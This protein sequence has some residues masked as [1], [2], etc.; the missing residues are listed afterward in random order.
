M[1]ITNLEFEAHRNRIFYILLSIEQARI[2][3]LNDVTLTNFEDRF[4]L[5]QSK[6]K[7]TVQSAHCA[8]HQLQFGGNWAPCCPL[9]QHVPVGAGCQVCRRGGR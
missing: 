2:N 7:D 9:W 1:K 6:A 4:Q 3:M 5:V 8:V